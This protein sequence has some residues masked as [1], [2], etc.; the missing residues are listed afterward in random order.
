[1]TSDHSTPSIGSLIHS[2]EPVPILAVGPGL[3]SDDVN[4][5]DEQASRKGSIGPICGKDLMPLIL[6]Y[7]N[8][9]RLLGT[10]SF[11]K[12]FLARPTKDRAI[13]LRPDATYGE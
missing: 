7:S 9:I 8:R 6:N 10:R 13:P 2:G 5:F 11:S 3:G 4:T 12:D 1:M